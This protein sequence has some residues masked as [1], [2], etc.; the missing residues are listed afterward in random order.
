MKRI[1]S[2]LDTAATRASVRN[3]ILLARK[4]E[5]LA[6]IMHGSPDPDAIASAMALREILKQKAGV[7]SCAFIA[8]DAVDRQQNIDLIRALKIDIGLIGDA[9]LASRPLIALVDAQPPFLGK[10]LG[11]LTPHI[12]LDHHPRVGGW[13]AEL[14][15]IREHYGALSTIL[16]E[17][18]LTAKARIPRMLHSALLYG[19]KT[20]TNNLE[21]NCL[22]EDLGA[23]YLTFTHANR[24]LIR[25]I[26]FNQIP[27]RFL[28]YYNQAFRHHR[29]YRDRIICFLGKV[30]S[31]D[32]CVQVADFF[33]HLIDIY[34]VVIAGIVK[35]KLV[36]VLRGDGY[37]QD[38]G[39][40]AERA[41]GIYGA[42]GGH[43]SAARVEIALD[44]FNETQ[45]E[46]LSREAV[47]RFLLQSL[48]ESSLPKAG[49]AAPGKMG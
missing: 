34:T 20:D 43:R 18:L 4:K 28:K 40:V 39:A 46:D 25:R 26:E 15:D 44:K 14:E 2:L 38:C 41:F 35:D 27:D 11:D 32:V 19:I 33:L 45:T 49:K 17:Y 7:R 30:E 36:I 12:V 29:R 42:A 5:A 6:V 21:R 22:L 13:R 10:A 3:L 16:T 47:D 1:E 37:R 24:Q 48:R 23:Y 31:H 8:T 9:D